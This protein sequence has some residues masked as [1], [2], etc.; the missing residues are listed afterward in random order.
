MGVRE[1]KEA[2]KR[3]VRKV[4]RQSKEVRKRVSNKDFL[5]G[6][7]VVRAGGGKRKSGV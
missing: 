1:S 6:N 2:I 3:G 4:R 7:E 5:K